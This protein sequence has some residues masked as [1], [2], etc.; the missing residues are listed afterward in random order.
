MTNVKGGAITSR[1]FLPP[2]WGRLSYCL[3]LNHWIGGHW[4]WDKKKKKDISYTTSNKSARTFI[5][6]RE[7]KKQRLSTREDR[8]GGKDRK[9]KKWGEVILPT[10][11]GSFLARWTGKKK[12]RVLNSHKRG[13]ERRRTLI[14]G[15]GGAGKDYRLPFKERQSFIPSMSRRGGEARRLEGK[16]R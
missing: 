7:K 11:G 10:T 9:M 13:K 12:K 16:K 5:Q 6:L 8:R 2:F 15:K 1:F 4:V 14:W 3:R